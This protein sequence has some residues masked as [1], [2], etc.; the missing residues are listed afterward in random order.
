MTRYFFIAGAFRLKTTHL[1]AVYVTQ[2]FFSRR[3]YRL[4]DLVS[5]ETRFTPPLLARSPL[6]L[7]DDTLRDPSNPNMQRAM[8]QHPLKRG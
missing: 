4:K 8:L 1:L 6:K 2:V 5:E 7:L 3:V